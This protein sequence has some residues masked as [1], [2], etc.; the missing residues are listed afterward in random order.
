MLPSSAVAISGSYVVKCGRTGSPE[1]RIMSFTDDHHLEWKGKRGKTG[2]VDL[3]LLS[4]VHIGQATQIFQDLAADEVV[5]V[6]FSLIL[7]DRT[8]DLV[9][10]SIRERQQWID[11][12][13]D[14]SKITLPESESSRIVDSVASQLQAFSAHTKWKPAQLRAKF[15]ELTNPAVRRNHVKLKS[16]VSAVV[17]SQILRR[18][19]HA[20]EH[21]Q[22]SVTSDAEHHVPGSESADILSGCFTQLSAHLE[23]NA[24]VKFKADI[25]MALDTLLDDHVLSSVPVWIHSPLAKFLQL[26]S[27]AIV[28]APQ[29]CDTVF[30][31]GILQK[32]FSI[33]DHDLPDALRCDVLFLLGSLAFWSESCSHA[34]ANQNFASI[35]KFLDS[36]FEG[37]VSQEAARLIG[38]VAYNNS[39]FQNFCR[40]KGVLQLFLNFCSSSHQ[41]HNNIVAVA[42]NRMCSGNVANFKL[43]KQ[44]GVI[45]RLTAA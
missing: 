4:D 35:L 30:C 7:S 22:G 9:V 15:V 32:L 6:S 33:L 21:G 43:L 18:L 39:D 20:D 5:D 42:I 34:L 45:D 16:A 24:N 27:Q 13:L 29:N 26:L 28:S 3:H 1:M 44:S 41:R 40:D 10:S 8:L 38:L 14:V 37:S 2:T 36:S 25:L 23:G 12:V 17:S 31:S 19:S 11:A